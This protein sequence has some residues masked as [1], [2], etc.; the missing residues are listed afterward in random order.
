VAVGAERGSRGAS[1][2]APDDAVSDMVVCVFMT[3][4][5]NARSASIPMVE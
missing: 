4:A 1:A 5:L 2:G 3:G